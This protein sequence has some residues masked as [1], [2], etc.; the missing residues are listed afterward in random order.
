MIPA[1]VLHP[2]LY[3]LPDV[4]LAV[5]VQTHHIVDVNRALAL[6]YSRGELIGTDVRALAADPTT[7]ELDHLLAA[8]ARPREVAFRGR[9]A[10]TAIISVHA[11][12]AETNGTSAVDSFAL[13]THR[14]SPERAAERDELRDLRARLA[15]ILEGLERLTERVAT[16]PVAITRSP[17]IELPMPSH[18]DAPRHLEAER[19]SAHLPELTLEQYA[20]LVAECDVC[21]ERRAE[22]AGRYGVLSDAERAELDRSWAKRFAADAVLYERKSALVG[23]YVEWYR[24]QADP[25][26]GVK[27]KAHS[28]SKERTTAPSATG[29]RPEAYLPFAP[30]A[31]APASTESPA[32]AP[33]MSAG[34]RSADEVRRE[35]RGTVGVTSIGRGDALPFKPPEV[36]DL[37]VEQYAAMMA[38][39]GGYP[40]KQGEIRAMYGIYSEAVWR[41][42]DTHWTARLAHDP[43]LKQKWLRLVAEYAKSLVGPAS[44][45]AAPMSRR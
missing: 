9:H 42:C 21:P 29:A 43:A 7:L 28:G 35:L 30:I 20:S 19:S 34:E 16:P 14:E 18:A 40:D 36:P 10:A 41:L 26:Q 45:R 44:S 38:E 24:Q 23:H 22:I 37:S 15:G 5:D 13:L 12:K 6:G 33:A 8:N 3:E 17:S 2:S 11:S 27:A 4:T 39:L 25:S 31:L 1:N 32:S